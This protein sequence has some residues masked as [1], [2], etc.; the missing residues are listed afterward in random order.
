MD[1]PQRSI[2]IVEDHVPTT[3]VMVRLVEA[4][5]FKVFA[6]HSLTQAREI[7]G[8]QDIGFVISDLGLPDGNGGDLMR[9]LQQRFGLAGAALTG[10]GMD[11]DI[12]QAQQSGF[13]M[14]VTKPIQIGDLDKVLALATSELAKPRTKPA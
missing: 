11:A 14:H 3:K 9:E 12:A 2:L 13:V 4:R 1:N 6:A 10:Y 7:A 8:K 5:G